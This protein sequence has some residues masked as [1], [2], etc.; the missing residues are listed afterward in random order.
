MPS[1]E[2]KARTVPGLAEFTSEGESVLPLYT[3]VL[4]ES[5]PEEYIEKRF[6]ACIGALMMPAEGLDE[7]LKST[8]DRLM[9]Y[10]EQAA[11]PPPRRNPESVQF[12]ADRAQVVY[13]PEFVAGE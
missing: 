12:M 8:L 1:E 7:H 11:L 10:N 6:F 2:I 5:E 9:Y 13:R 3:F 4:V